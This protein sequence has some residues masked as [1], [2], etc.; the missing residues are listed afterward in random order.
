[1]GADEVGENAFERLVLE[2]DDVADDTRMKME[3]SNVSDKVKMT[4]AKMIGS[5]NIKLDKKLCYVPTVVCVNGFD[6]V[7]FDEELVNAGSAKWNL[8]LRGYFVEIKMNFNELTY[9][10][11]RMWT[12]YGLGEMFATTMMS[13]ALNSNMNMAW[14]AK[15]ISTLASSLGKPPIMDDM[16]TQMCQ[17]G[18]GMIGYVRVLVEVSACKE[19]KEFIEFQYKDD[20]GVIV[21]SKKIKVEYSWKPARCN[22]CL[23]KTVE[24][25][26]KL[27]EE[28]EKNKVLANKFVPLEVTNEKSVKKSANNIAN[29][30]I[31]AHNSRRR[32]ILVM[33]LIVCRKRRLLHHTKLQTT[34]FETSKWSYRMVNYFK[35]RWEE[36]NE[37]QENFDEDEVIEDTGAQTKDLNRICSKVFGMR[38]W[39]SNMSKGCRITVGWNPNDV[40][41]EVLIGKLPMKYIGVPLLA[42]CLGNADCKVFIDK[43]DAKVGD[44][45]NKCLSHVGRVNVISKRDIY[46]ARFCNN[47]TVADMIKD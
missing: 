10:L 2:R 12:R 9:K 19:F 25:M 16:T 47:A 20:K 30:E 22:D 35:D 38:N 37:Q 28:K 34:P 3:L 40:K 29:K 18:K 17:Y 32:K 27:Q 31:S 24:E 36:R 7:I 15:G 42:K 14:S 23:S 21:R 8:T 6:V 46:D 13:I 26:A 44:R 41:V 11:M 43:V 5:K 45:K 33:R 1:M 39:A 4:Y